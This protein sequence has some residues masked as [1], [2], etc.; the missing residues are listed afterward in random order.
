MAVGNSCD[1]WWGSNTQSKKPLPQASL[2]EVGQLPGQHLLEGKHVY[3]LLGFRACK[4]CGQSSW[5]ARMFLTSLACAA[6]PNPSFQ[7]L[8]LPLLMNNHLVI[9]PSQGRGSAEGLLKRNDFLDK[10]ICPLG[11]KSAACWIMLSWV[12]VSTTNFVGG[13]HEGI[14]T[15]ERVSSA[16]DPSSILEAEGQTSQ[17]F[18]IWQCRS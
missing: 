17:K 3:N 18:P 10:Y 2:S 1:E 5:W 7:S 6:V 4:V 11:P 16:G 8:A 12:Q 14:P 15:M 13:A 9:L